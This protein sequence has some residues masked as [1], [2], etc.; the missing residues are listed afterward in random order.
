MKVFVIG[1]GEMFYSLV[2]GVLDSSCEV[3]G[4]FRADNL[5]KS[6]FKRRLNDIFLPSND[7]N[8]VK[9]LNLKE[10]YAPS[11]NSE[12]FKKELKK[13]NPDVILVG[14]WS[15]KLKADVINIPKI[16]CINVHPS[17]LPKYRG[18]NP[19]YQVI[20]S[21]EKT[22]GITFHLMDL[23]YDT[24]EILHQ[25]ETEIFNTDTGLSLK[26]RCCDL[27]RKELKNLLE[28]LLE[29]IEKAQVQNEKEASYQPQ[30]NIRESILDF[31]NETTDEIS[32]RIRA[33]SPWLKCHIAY[34]DEFFDFKEYT[35]KPEITHNQPSCIVDKKSDSISV[36]AKDLKVIEFKGLKLK[37]PFC[38][39][40]TKFYI[41]NFVKINSKVR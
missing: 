40:F 2:L 8:F 24:G 3:A 30:I 36:S 18:P 29:K 34:N 35:I 37:R 16:A 17:L 26:L 19:Y 31:N 27:A 28:N 39:F 20:L 1:Y 12:K 21:G 38:S 32:R 25:A 7:Y 33:L 23:N 11:V 4:V 10:I 22:T 41:K 9:S 5:K 15:E 6:A 13:L 14:S